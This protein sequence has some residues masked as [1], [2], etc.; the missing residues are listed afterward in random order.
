MKNF[1]ITNPYKIIDEAS[2][3]T[4]LDVIKYYNDVAP[5]ML[6]FVK[7]RL[8][9]V[10]RCHQ[11]TGDECFF[12]KHPSNNK[13]MVEVFFDDDE[14]YFYLSSAD[15]FLYQVQMGTI[16]FHPWA[17]N[18]PKI[19]SPNIMIFDLDPD[20]NMPLEQLRQGVVDLKRILDSLHLQSFL[21]T[22]GG[23]GYHIVLPFSSTSNFETFSSFANSI[24]LL[25]ESKWP[26]LY[27]TNMRKDQR[28]GKIFI[29][30]LRNK[31]GS[32]CAATYSL[33]SR[34]NLPI[35][36]PIIWEDLEKIA[37]NDVNISNYKKYIKS[38]PWEDFFKVK[39]RLK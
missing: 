19:D 4:K 32:T 10:I 21:K 14:E 3:A 7:N 23:K 12:K 39:Q 38:N 1:E 35:S 16:E 13:D 36:C 8:L 6:P 33:R 27:T 20:K 30:W 15:Q 22:S 5:L 18:V 24:A 34:E 17:S 9:S 25:M 29:D 11:G 31:R 26:K 2:K 37:P 28:K